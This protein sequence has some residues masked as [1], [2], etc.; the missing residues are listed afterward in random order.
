TR[1]DLMEP[2]LALAEA[3]DAL[4]GTPLADV[5][6]VCVSAVTGE[7]VDELRSELAALGSALPAADPTADVRLWVD[8]SF[9]I[10]GA[11]TGVPGT[12]L[13]GTRRTGQPGGID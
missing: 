5:P 1:S 4:A 8:R 7:G 10:G 2:E 6:A 9:T 3:R 11:G 13:A 12:P